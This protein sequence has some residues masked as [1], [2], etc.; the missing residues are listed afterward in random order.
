M[1]YKDKLFETMGPVQ[2]AHPYVSGLPLPPGRHRP[3]EGEAPGC[4][5]RYC[6]DAAHTGQPPRT[7]E[8]REKIWRDIWKLPSPDS[9][10][11]Q[12][13]TQLCLPSISICYRRDDAKGSGNADN[14]RSL[15]TAAL[16]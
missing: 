8:G 5:R 9:Q 7:W 10:Q 12:P 3:E 15:I 2:G 16:T 14:Q 6:A 4:C 11:P 13:W 1:I